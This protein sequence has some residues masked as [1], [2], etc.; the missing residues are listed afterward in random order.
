MTKLLRKSQDLNFLR[1][2]K[3]LN[4][5]IASIDQRFEGEFD[6]RLKKREKCQFIAPSL[7]ALSPEV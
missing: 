1:H 6:K 7:K 3:L 4:P 2:N 5:Q